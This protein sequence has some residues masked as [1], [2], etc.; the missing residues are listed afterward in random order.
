MY[1]TQQRVTLGPVS[2]SPLAIC[3]S[4]LFPAVAMRLSLDFVALFV[5]SSKFDARELH[6]TFVQLAFNLWYLKKGHSPRSWHQT[7]VGP[8]FRSDGAATERYVAVWPFGSY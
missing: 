5:D 7:V 8:L 4:A 6:D 1:T 2:S 3:P